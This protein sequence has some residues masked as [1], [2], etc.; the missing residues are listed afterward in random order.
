MALLKNSKHC[1]EEIS[2]V[3]ARSTSVLTP[4]YIHNYLI[5]STHGVLIDILKP[6]LGFD[7]VSDLK[8]KFQKRAS[9][10]NHNCLPFSLLALAVEV[11][12]TPC[13]RQG[14]WVYY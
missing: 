8:P 3:K 10:R 5:E 4:I 6:L 9:E 2:F 7:P 13:T 1:M 14:Y 12:C 11:R